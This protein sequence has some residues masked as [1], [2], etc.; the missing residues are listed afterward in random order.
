MPHGWP[1]GIDATTP[2]RH[3]IRLGLPESRG[4][5]KP[6]RTLPVAVRQSPQPTR[7][8][9]FKLLVTESPRVRSHRDSDGHGHGPARRSSRGTYAAAEPYKLMMNIVPL[10]KRFW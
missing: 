1:C 4:H 8:F 9:N 6:R 2:R 5:G 3:D 7:P 10:Q